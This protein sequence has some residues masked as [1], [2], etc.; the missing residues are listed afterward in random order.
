M[1]KLCCICNSKGPLKIDL[2]AA[3]DMVTV[4][5]WQ[6][7]LMMIEVC[8]EKAGSIRNHGAN[9]LTDKKDN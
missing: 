3:I 4:S 8:F 1:R 6:A 2:R 9:A 7:K 5:W